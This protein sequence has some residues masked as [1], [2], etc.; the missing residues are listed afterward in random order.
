[1]AVS[2]ST[3]CRNNMLDGITTT[4]GTSGQIIIYTGSAPAV[5]SAATGTVLVTIPCATTFAAAASSATLTFNGLPL[6]ATASAS[7]T[8]GY[9]R[10]YKSD[11]TTTVIQG[12]VTATGG[13]GD[14]TF[15][16]VSFV[17]GATI[18]ITTAS[19]TAGNA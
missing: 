14:M 13:G 2:L 10:V 8:A 18:S 5:G 15:A 17:S 6:S 16:T 19:F 12:T 9:F 4:V 7:G 3:T 11:G 1:M